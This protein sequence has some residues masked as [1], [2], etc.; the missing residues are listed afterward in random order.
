[1]LLAG[2]LVFLA[3]DVWAEAPAAASE[4]PAPV[5]VKG[6]TVEYF[7]EQEKVVGTGNVRINYEDIKLSADKIT[8]Y[9]ATNL[10]VAEGNVVLVQS[11][12]TFKGERGEYDFKKNSGNVEGMSAE[13]G[14]NLFAKA[15][16]V[17]RV[18]EDH[19]RASD[20]YVTTCCGDNPFYRIQAKTVDVYPG[21]K[22]V[23][24]NA[25]LLVKGV[26]ILFIP[27]YVQ[28]FVDFDRFPVQL[29]PG[30]SSEWGA[31]LLSR[32]RYQLADSPEFTS[33]GN[34]LLD[35]RVK[36]GFAGGVENFYRGE[37]IGRGAAR[38]YYAHDEDA[39]E[40][41]SSDR[42]R[43]QYRHQAKLT[44]ST[45]FTTE[46]NRLSDSTVVKDFFFREEYER[47]AIPDSYVSIITAKP[48]Y[49]LSFLDRERVNDFQTVV[50][51]SPEIRFDTH[52]R[53]FADTNFYLR[54]EFQFSSLKKEFGS[55]NRQEDATRFDTNQTLLY[56]G[57]VGALSVTPRVG[58]RQTYYSRRLE[59]DGDL[60]RGTFDPG[61]DLSTRF[62]KTYDAY[63]HAL[64]LDYNQIRHIFT[65]TASYN[66]RPNPTV[67]RSLLAQFDQI[68]AIDK[69]NYV[70]INLENKLQTKEHN[71]RNVF[72][73]REIARAIPFF[74]YDFDTG[75]IDNVG[76]DVELRPYSWMGI[77]AD[78][79]FETRT[80][81]VTAANADFYFER[82]PYRFGIGQRYVQEESA[83]TTAEFR[84]KIS[85]EW[86]VKVYERYEFQEKDSKEF[87]FTVSKVFDCVIADFSYNHR[88][89]DTFFVV[90]RLKGYEA[91]SFRLSQSYNRPKSPA[92]ASSRIL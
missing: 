50:E 91:A 8:V 44:D 33:R 41:I 67:T 89:G 26:P 17:D 84:W 21:K 10:A 80:G 59:N 40:E 58:T 11:G 9:T 71:E 19:Y 51:R 81:K 45:T 1:L 22:V 78:A 20:S 28:N 18:S 82:G 30:K 23:V 27:I 4:N 86:A 92:P 46:F 60:V 12:G 48:E 14:P 25:L 47:D 79:E 35:Y 57:R 55:T 77:D 69:Q 65:P 7:H 13:I 16:R 37:K 76:L 24:K 3:S 38:I 31:F 36:R 56:A 85:D 83:Q 43:V 73:S 62:F 29:V 2:S 75:R 90:F 52:N 34:V 68:D 5:Q 87:E 61:L 15:K 39:P 6:D 53:R 54:Q 88:E 70:R 49:T 63:V 74:D 72:V 64:G 32:W 42:F 66:Y